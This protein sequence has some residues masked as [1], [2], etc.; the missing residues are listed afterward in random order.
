MEDWQTGDEPGG[1]AAASPRES[2][3]AVTKRSLRKGLRQ[4]VVVPLRRLSRRRIPVAMITGTKGKSTTVRMLEHILACAGHKVGVA[5]SDGIFIDGRQLKA[6]DSSGYRGGI[7]VLRHPSISAAVLETARGD[8]LRRG[9]CLDRCEVAA[10]LNVGREQIGIDGID[11]LEQ[12]AALKRRVTDAGREAVVLNADDPH[13]RRVA[14]RYPPGRVVFFSSFPHS[15]AVRRHRESG[16]RVVC[17]DRCDGEEFLFSCSGPAA[18]ALLAAA[19]IPATWGGVARHN[20]SNAM[21]AAALAEGLHVPRSLIAE[22]LRSFTNFSELLPARFNLVTEFPF[23]VVLDLAIN[24]VAAEALVASLAKIHV[25][26]Q[27]LCMVTSF[28]NRPLSHFRELAGTLAPHFQRFICYEHDVYRRQRAPG[29][30]STILSAAL[31]QA[32][33]GKERI[34]T[35]LEDDRALRQLLSEAR[36]GDLLAILG[37]RPGECLGVLRRECR[38]GDPVQW[39]VRT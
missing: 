38:P 5:S 33:V 8:L 35:A 10:L 20:I 25:R 2:R 27:R 21:A 9:R 28:G 37:G 13:C 15:S 4:A 18:E 32:G 11:S 14:E 39:Q 17:L 31:H 26:G 7:T 36:P 29:E 23:L 30:I 12:M 6:H 22:G 34:S 1:G 3:L 16:G 19:A 24:P